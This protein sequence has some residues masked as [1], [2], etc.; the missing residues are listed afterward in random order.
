MQN[1]VGGGSRTLVSCLGGQV[2]G[3]YSLAAGSVFHRVATSKA[4]RNLPDPVPAVLLG[5]LAVDRNWQGRGL[6][7]DLLRDAALRVAG[8]A[9]TIGVRVFLVHALSDDARRFYERYGFRASPLEPM[10]LMITIDELRR[11][12]SQLQ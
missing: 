5:R 9:D 7:G 11:G 4:R 12:I 3:Y 2:V 1:E 6:G 10:T 8:A